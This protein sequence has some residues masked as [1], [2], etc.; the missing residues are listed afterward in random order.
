MIASATPRIDVAEA[1][2]V[3][4]VA[5]NRFDEN[6]TPI[7][8]ARAHVSFGQFAISGTAHELRVVASALSAAADRAQTSDIE[9]RERVKVR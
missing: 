8:E 5:C 3:T 6:R 7:E 2:E 9:A 4:V 1:P